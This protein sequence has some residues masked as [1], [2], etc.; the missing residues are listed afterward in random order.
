[1]TYEQTL[2]VIRTS[3]GNWEQ[4]AGKGKSFSEPEIKQIMQNAEKILG[5]RGLGEMVYPPTDHVQIDY[6]K[7][8]IDASIVQ[9]EHAA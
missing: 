3:L 1:M 8:I 4:I 6:L 5:G 7:T 9:F 2:E